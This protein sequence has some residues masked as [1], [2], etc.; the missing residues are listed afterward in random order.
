MLVTVRFDGGDVPTL[1]AIAEQL[2]YVD[3]VG[4][5]AAIEHAGFGPR[6]PEDR[7]GVV[8]EYELATGVPTTVRIRGSLHTAFV[9]EFP[10]SFG[11]VSI[12]NIAQ[13]CTASMSL[14]PGADWAPVTI[15]IDSPGRAVVRGA[16]GT[17]ATVDVQVPIPGTDQFIE[18]VD[19]GDH[20]DQPWSCEVQR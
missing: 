13:G 16:D 17:T 7:S 19:L 18:V 6:S 3:D 2:I 15:L 11:S 14:A 8:A 10:T 12:P 9:I 5:E 4:W 1:I 20:P